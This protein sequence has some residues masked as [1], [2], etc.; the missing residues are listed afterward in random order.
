M[1]AKSE[2]SDYVILSWNTKTAK[3]PLGL[4]YTSVNSHLQSGYIP[5]G[6]LTH[7]KFESKYHEYTQAMI[8]SKSGLRYKDYSILIRI[9][10]R[11]MT[12]KETQQNLSRDVY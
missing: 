8:V 1:D 11:D 5:Y 6:N 4:F 12:H 9:T 10:C 7:V 2:A 3:D